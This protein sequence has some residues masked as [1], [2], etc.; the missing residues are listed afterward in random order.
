MVGEVMSRV[1]GPLLYRRMMAEHIL[2]ECLVGGGR[3]GGKRSVS[4]VYNEDGE[5]DCD[6]P[7]AVGAGMILVLARA[8]RAVNWGNE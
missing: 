2:M 6:Q 3:E 5:V 7:D 8:S 1:P 4:S